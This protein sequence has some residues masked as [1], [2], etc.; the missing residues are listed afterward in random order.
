MSVCLG[1]AAEAGTE[2]DAFSTRFR[3]AELDDRVIRF[4]FFR[5]TD[6]NICLASLMSVCLRHVTEADVF[7]SGFRAEKLDARFIRF[8]F[9]RFTDINSLPSFCGFNCFCCY[10]CYCCDNPKPS[11]FLCVMSSSFVLFCLLTRRRLVS[12]SLFLCVLSSSFA[13]LFADSP[14]LGLCIAF[15]VCAEFIL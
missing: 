1:L 3:A 8:R 9:F 13:L 14:A 2:T 5:F 10:C 15:S 12:A 6:I 4:R 11:L 7:S